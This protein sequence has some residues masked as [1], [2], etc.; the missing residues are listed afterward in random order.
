M[1]YI[2]DNTLPNCKIEVKK[3]EWGE[4]Y[5]IY[6]PIFNF[7]NLSD[8]KLENSIKLFGENNFKQQLLLMYNVINNYEE[9]EKLE[10]YKGEKFSRKS[11]LELINFYLKKNENLI[12]PWEKYDVGLSE[13][14][15]IKYIEEKLSE[16]LYYVK[17]K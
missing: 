8:S 5:K 16:A 3:F 10:N 13:N 17:V 11:I 1:N 9:L 6:T 14:D 4:P 2:D 12:T 7:T 15:Y